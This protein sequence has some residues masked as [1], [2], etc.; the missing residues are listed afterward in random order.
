MADMSKIDKL[1]G[2]NL[3]YM[4]MAGARNIIDYQADI[5]SINVYPVA[6]GDTGTN[7]AS[8]I[9]TVVDQIR[10]DGSFKVTADQIG[11]AALTG[12]RGNSGIIFAQFLFGFAEEIRE[13]TEITIKEF[14]ESLE[15]S[16]KYLYEAVANPVEGTILTVIREWV[17]YIHEHRHIF[18]DFSRLMTESYEVA[19]TSLSETKDKLAE[20]TKANVVDAGAKGFVVFLEGMKDLIL[21]KNIKE[22]VGMANEIR[23][24]PLVEEIPSVYPDLRYCTE[25]MLEG[26]SMD[27]DGIKKLLQDS[28]DSVVVAG[29]KRKV[30]LHVHTNNPADLFVSLRDYGKITFQKVE[31]MV[32][33]YESAHNRKYNIALVTDSTNDLPDEIVE[34]Y[35]IHIVPI[36]LYVAGNS[37]LDGLTLK[38]DEFYRLM[39]QTSELPSTSQPSPSSFVNL[40]S[41]LV[42]RY[43]SVIA[44]HIS[45][46][47]SGTYNTSLN[48]A[49]KISEESGKKIDVIDSGTISG[50]A[51]LQV[52]K[53]AEMIGKGSSHE[54][55][56]S[57]ALAARKEAN[58]FVSVRTLKY[59]IRS[60]RVSPLKGFIAQM[61]KVKPVVSV[62]GSG[63]A[64]LI[65]KAFTYKANRKKVISCIK[66][67]LAGKELYGY[68][69]NHVFSPDEAHY[70]IERMM[71][72][73][74][75]DPL[76]ISSVSPAIGLHT[77]KG[78]VAVTM[79]TE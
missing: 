58:I 32:R 23:M 69:I 12:A 26:D 65:G 5:N 11:V 42:T 57:A 64:V 22:V 50:A 8:T 43:D 31:D 33:Q 60:G 13:C 35:Q 44:L 6:D 38:A 61:L 62:E 59:F 46:G 39:D 2:R 15:R 27:K 16:V 10:L 36:S 70:F 18:D 17:E 56:V 3:Y 24:S 1:D 53:I 68:S 76:F 40:Y 72:I 54:E 29:S 63:K 74:G 28:G 55:I 21:K 9:R 78:T 14:A 20:L 73:T 49:R 75:M 34:K 37:Y 45:D 19:K 67:A 71:E 4:F 51:G 66:K 41:Q 52:I 30:R 47:L 77:G 48:A 79:L 25:A 7:M